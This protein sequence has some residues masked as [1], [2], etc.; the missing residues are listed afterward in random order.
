M[1]GRILKFLHNF[2]INRKEVK[3]NKNDLRNVYTKIFLHIEINTDGI[4]LKYE[5]KFFPCS[6]EEIWLLIMILPTVSFNCIPEFVNI[7]LSKA[8][9]MLRMIIL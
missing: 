3:K 8:R 4:M 5:V 6:K 9:N 7:V 1:Y 2:F